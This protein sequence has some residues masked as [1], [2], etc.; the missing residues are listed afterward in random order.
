MIDARMTIPKDVWR[1]E[2]LLYG[3]L[4][5][6]GPQSAAAAV[7][8]VTADARTAF[9][10]FL[11]LAGLML[12]VF[13]EPPAAWFA[14]AEPQTTDRRP[15]LLAA[16]L[17]VGYVLT[18]AVPAARE[19]FSFAVPRPT[20]TALVLLAFAIWLP[21]V[22]VFWKRRLLE[23]FLGLGGDPGGPGRATG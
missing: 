15:A 11:V 14:V 23:R 2:V 4:V 18:L 7:E 6:A 12:V 9:T 19:F 13:V 20:D 1:F 21:L 3:S 8:A 17:A 5:L 10:S 22:R 16:L